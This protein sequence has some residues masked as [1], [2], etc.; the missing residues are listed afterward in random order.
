MESSF[1]AKELA[2]KTGVVQGATLPSYD[3]REA[4]PPMD[5]FIPEGIS[6]SAVSKSADQFSVKPF[7]QRGS[8]SPTDSFALIEPTAAQMDPG[9]SFSIPF[10]K[11]MGSN[12][13]ASQSFPSDL[14]PAQY[15]PAGAHYQ[16]NSPEGYL[17]K[18]FEANQSSRAKQRSIDPRST[19]N[20]D[21]S[22]VVYGPPEQRSSTSRTPSPKSP[23][24]ASFAPAAAPSYVSR[25]VASL[26]S[27]AIGSRT[28]RTPSAVAPVEATMTSDGYSVHAPGFSVPV[29]GNVQQPESNLSSDAVRTILP[30]TVTGRTVSPAQRVDASFGLRTSKGGDLQQKISSRYGLIPLPSRVFAAAS[31]LV[32]KLLNPK[33]STPSSSE[34]IGILPGRKVSPAP[35]L[36]IPIGENSIQIPDRSSVSTFLP[37]GELSSRL[38][39]QAEMD[40]ITSEIEATNRAQSD[41]NKKLLLI[42]GGIAAAGV[43]LYIVS[44]G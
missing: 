32:S 4:L 34:I 13:S 24:D 15:V 18:G 36:T 35:N 26:A 6:A 5:S 31:P 43:A 10:V 7:S 14:P 25:V 40:Q 41:K 17:V 23:L 12:Y 38:A 21:Y 11:E 33:L 39:D 16:S 9:E 42:C 37:E 2:Q 44:K 3:I 1:Q 28:S 20:A 27:G 19:V 8:L 30:G 29:P 22:P